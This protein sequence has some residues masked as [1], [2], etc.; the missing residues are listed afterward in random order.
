MTDQENSILVDLVKEVKEMHSKTDG[1]YQGL[2]G[3]PNTEDKGMCGAFKELKIDYYKF[4]Q[5]VL[6]VF[7]FLVGSGVLGIG[8]WELIKVI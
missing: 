3:V 8:I 7:Y 5:K 2:Y 4:K 1:I 6:V